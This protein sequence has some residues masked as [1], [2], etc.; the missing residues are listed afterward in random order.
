MKKY[1]LS[2]FALMATTAS[3]AQDKVAANLLHSRQ[4]D[5]NTVCVKQHEL[6]R[7]TPQQMMK[8]PRKDY[9]SEMWYARPRGTFYYGGSYVD[10]E[11]GETVSF[12]Y[13]VV[14]PFME[15][16]FEN[17][18]TDA[19]STSWFMEDEELTENI[20][21][22]GNLSCLFY[23]PQMGYVNLLP[24]LQRGD[25]SFQ[26]AD[27][28]L[29]CDS[30]PQFVHAYDFLLG[31]RYAVGY[32][33]GSSAFKSG[34]DYFDW[35]DDGNADVFYTESFLTFFEKPASPMLLYDVY[36][37]CSAPTN[38]IDNM[39]D[40][41]LVFRRVERDAEG[42]RVPADTIKILNCTSWEFDDEVLSAQYPYY[43]GDALFAA[44]EEDE[45][46]TPTATPFVI[47]C[48][49]CI[50]LTGFGLDEMEI[51]FIFTDQGENVEEFESRATPTYFVCVDENEEHLGNLS[52]FN[53]YTNSKGETVRYCYNIAYMFDVVFD[54]LNVEEGTEIHTAPVEGGDSESQEEQ[55][56]CTWLYTNLPIFE[57]DGEEVLWTD[58]YDFDGIPE[59]AQIKID[60]SY[61]ENEEAPNVRG[62]NLIWFEVEPLPEGVEGRSASIKVVSA[63]GIESSPIT[64]VQGNAV[65][66]GVSYVQFDA[67]GKYVRSYNLGGQVVSHSKGITIQN[68]KKYLTK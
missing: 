11:T 4:L 34:P 47:D 68:G 29:V 65:P 13:I 20:D 17:K 64:L 67:D 28:A 41:Q 1:L 48:E 38:K 57:T 5:V 62:L 35:D 14:P 66:E 42:Y 6:T 61:Y 43:V 40:L 32:E 55:L 25:D 60:P 49:Y 58:N 45:F 9:D 50:Y 31:G 37:L 54:G 52:Y 2:L 3:F 33:D 36:L 24:S 8:A 63:T 23:K 39:G 18:S 7:V 30:M 21:A 56:Q 16:Q 53:K 44:E 46:G 26:I 19:A 22:D 10:D 15:M 27:Y 12:K 51:G 59:W